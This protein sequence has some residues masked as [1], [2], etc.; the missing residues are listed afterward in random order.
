MRAHVKY[1]DARNFV[2]TNHIFCSLPTSKKPSQTYFLQMNKIK[3]QEI[4]I[5]HM[6]K[7]KIKH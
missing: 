1:N 7:S 2:K 4:M 3:K 6:T 5:L